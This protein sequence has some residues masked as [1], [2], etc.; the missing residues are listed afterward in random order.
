MSKVKSLHGAVDAQGIMAIA[1]ERVEPD[2]QVCV[3]ILKKSG[4]PLI[5]R[6]KMDARDMSYCASLMTHDLLSG[7]SAYV[8][9]E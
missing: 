8:S 3:I 6:T 4:N 1:S 7:F 2:D 5:C 9:E